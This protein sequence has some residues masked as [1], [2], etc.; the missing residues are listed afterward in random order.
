[1]ST[2]E[3][4]EISRFYNDWK[5]VCLENLTERLCLRGSLHRESWEL[6]VRGRRCAHCLNLDRAAPS[7]SAKLIKIPLR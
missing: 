2:A 4:N 3:H 1:M 6:R 7:S 5:L